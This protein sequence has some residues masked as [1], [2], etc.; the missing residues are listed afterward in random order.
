[1]AEIIAPL[2][3]K[4]FTIES[5]SPRALPAEDYAKAIS[6]YN[7]NVTACKSIQ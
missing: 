7:K 4:I 6:R 1:M 5:D 2:A 3:K